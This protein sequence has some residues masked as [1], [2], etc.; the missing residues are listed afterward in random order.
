V[1]WCS[2]RWSPRSAGVDRFRCTCPSAGRR[3]RSGGRRP[4]PGEA[5]VRHETGTGHRAG[6]TPDGGRAGHVAAADEV[7]GRS[8]EF[9]AALRPSPWPTSSSSLR[10]P[11][12][13]R[14]DTVIRADEAVTAPCS[15]GGRA[16]TGRR[17]PLR[18]LGAHRTADRGSSADPP[19]PGPGQNQY[20]F[21]PCWALDGRPATMTYFIT[22]AG[23]RWPVE[24]TFKTGK[25]ALGWD[26]CQART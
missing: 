14:Q 20:A 7:Y 3:T 18:R 19:L 21:Y 13:P 10:L 1:T 12:H 16:G 15:S 8:G 2:R 9:R 6:E 17:A 25:D 22:I 4:D 26:Q 23:R 24:I 11:G 5:D